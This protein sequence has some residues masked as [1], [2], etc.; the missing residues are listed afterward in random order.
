MPE[1]KTNKPNWSKDKFTEMVK[2]YGDKIAK[3]SE[4]V[5][6]ELQKML[7]ESQEV[8]LF[9][10]KSDKKKVE[11]KKVMEKVLT[12]N[13]TFSP[14][15]GYDIDDTT[16]DEDDIIEEP[17]DID[18]F[19]Y[20]ENNSD[21]ELNIGDKETEL[22]KRDIQLISK[23]AN[24]HIKE[25]FA[26]LGS[27]IINV[28]TEILLKGPG[29]VN[30]DIFAGVGEHLK[31]ALSDTYVNFAGRLY[32]NDYKFRKAYDYV[33]RYFSRNKIKIADQMLKL[34]EKIKNKH[35]TVDEINVFKATFAIF[36]ILCSGNYQSK[37]FSELAKVHKQG[38]YYSKVCR[39]FLYKL[40]ALT[41]TP[42]EKLDQAAE[43]LLNMD[44]KDQEFMAAI[45]FL[46]SVSVGSFNAVD[47]LY[48]RNNR[49]DQENG[50]FDKFIEEI[51]TGSSFR[52]NI[53]NNV[54]Y[55]NNNTNIV[56][57]PTICSLDLN[58]AKLVK[59]EIKNMFVSNNLDQFLIELV[60]KHRYLKSILNT[61]ATLPNRTV[62]PY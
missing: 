25:A 42:R 43:L 60:K 53:K 31:Q 21:D 2:E 16:I 56:G 1:E 3:I 38:K 4:D 51:S 36:S 34:A 10:E 14:I 58:N 57:S 7:E 33:S 46:V 22:S 54:F 17:D 8:N 20:V 45:L 12:E 44:P 50:K 27:N 9:L 39:E 5:E 48:K 49:I 13:S 62:E 55:F 29:L 15:L 47:F 52:H 19:N 30:L 26:K 24:P 18:K 59:K 61:N 41:G 6:K 40:D 37:T 28:A 23:I 11:L 35:A 32:D